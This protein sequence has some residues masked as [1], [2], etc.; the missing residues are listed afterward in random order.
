MI[1]SMISKLPA[2]MEQHIS[3]I[4]EA[5]GIFLLLDRPVCRIPIVLNH[6]TC[7]TD[8]MI[9]G[10]FQHVRPPYVHIKIADAHLI[11]TFHISTVSIWN[12]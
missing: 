4:F 9:R 8:T 1:V 6:H 11:I 5:F 3:K 12:R 2:L 7:I 10:K